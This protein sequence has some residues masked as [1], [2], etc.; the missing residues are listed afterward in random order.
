MCLKIAMTDRAKVV[1]LSQLMS[2]SNVFVLSLLFLGPHFLLCFKFIWSSLFRQ[3][4]S[5]ETDACLFQETV[6]ESMTVLERKNLRRAMYSKEAAT[7]EEEHE[8]ERSKFTN[9]P[10]RLRYPGLSITL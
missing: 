4:T 2:N 1:I 3:T 8:G 7:T 9:L 6:A 10:M 5:V